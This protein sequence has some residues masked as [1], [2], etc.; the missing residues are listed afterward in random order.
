MTELKSHDFDR[1]IASSTSLPRIILIFGPDQGLV[2]ERA[3]KVAQKTGVD[4]NDPFTVVQLTAADLTSDPG[5]LADEANSI[6]LFGGEKLVWVK[7]ASN[8]KQL[9]D[10]LKV[11]GENPP[12]GAWIIVEAGDLKKNAGLRKL[13]ASEKAISA[14]PCYADDSRALNGLIDEVLQQFQLRISNSARGLLISQ[15]GGDR[16]ASRNEIEKL[17]LY[18]LH[19]DTIE[20]HHVNEVIGDASGLSVDDAVNAVFTGNRRELLHAFTKL[21]ASK[22]PV[23]LVL[24]GVLKQ[25]QMLD[26]LKAEMDEGHMAP[27]AAIAKFARGLHFKKKPVVERALAAWPAQNMKREMERLQT[28]ILQ[29]RQN[30]I[31]EDSVALQL[32][33]SITLQSARMSNSR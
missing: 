19:E 5:R 18:C 29:S 12:S 3:K 22:T 28:C 6:G 27:P 8:E 32:L 30:A 16:K 2:S 13:A 24:Q 10:G 4:L 15:L 7:G 31:I 23:F 26:S 21:G 11:L 25:F 9:V 20:D 14:F 17:A 33:L 1:L